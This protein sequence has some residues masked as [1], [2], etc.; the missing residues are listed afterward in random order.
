MKQL[1]PESV[2]LSK[3]VPALGVVV[4]TLMFFSPLKGEWGLRVNT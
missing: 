4:A 1:L 2:F 3:V